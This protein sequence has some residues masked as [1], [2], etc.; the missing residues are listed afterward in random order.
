MAPRQSRLETAS[1]LSLIS[2][3][4]LPTRMPVVS[5]MPLM[6]PTLSITRSRSDF[7]RVGTS[8]RVGAPLPAWTAVPAVVV[9]HP[10][11]APAARTVLHSMIRRRL[12][13]DIL[14]RPGSRCG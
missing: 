3:E 10:D 1:E 5:M 12:T 2:S 14:P 13:A 11:N 4:V 8:V 7:C 6:T 9:T